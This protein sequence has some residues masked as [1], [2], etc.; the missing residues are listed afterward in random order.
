MV[1][2]QLGDRIQV[3]YAADV[4]TS[5]YGSGFGNEGQAILHVE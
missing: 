5:I 1:D 4:P 2:N 3:E